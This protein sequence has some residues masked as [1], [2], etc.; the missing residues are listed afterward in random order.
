MPFP[1]SVKEQI[2]A[3]AHG[4]CEGCRK[5][6]VLS[7]HTEGERGAWDAHHKISVRAGGKNVVSNGK[8]LCLDCH[9]MTRTYGRS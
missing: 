5:Q 7:N 2:F 6:L 3:K 1:D 9:K 4:K 8:A